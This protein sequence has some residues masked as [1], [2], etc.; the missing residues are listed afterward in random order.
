MMHTWRVQ[1]G[2]RLVQLEQVSIVKGCL[3]D[4]CQLLK[5]GHPA[6]HVSPSGT[7]LYRAATARLVLCPKWHAAQMSSTLKPK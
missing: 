3:V 1:E 4:A 7:I 6:Q 5:N 2:F